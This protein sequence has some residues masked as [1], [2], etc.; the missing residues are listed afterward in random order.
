MNLIKKKILY[1]CCL[2]FIFASCSKEDDI[3]LSSTNLEST[4][5][6]FFYLEKGDLIEKGIFR[7]KPEFPIDEK[8][9]VIFTTESKTKASGASGNGFYSSSFIS[10]LYISNNIIPNAI[11]VDLNEG[12]GGKYIYLCYEK[13]N[14]IGINMLNFTTSGSNFDI[15]SYMNSNY[16]TRYISDGNGIY[17]M[18]KGAGGDYVYGFFNYT[19]IPS[20]RITEIAIVSGDSQRIIY[21]EGWTRINVDLNSRAGGKYIYVFFKKSR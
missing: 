12:A 2:S 3:K 9:T 4:T 8:G 13:S 16:F 19:P 7:E 14:Y 5:V 17:D 18:N 10:N 6:P 1:L 20:D 15:D 11:P 21:G